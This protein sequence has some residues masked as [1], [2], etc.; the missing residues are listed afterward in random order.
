MNYVKKYKH[1][2]YLVLEDGTYIR[3]FSSNQ[4]CLDMNSFSKKE[5]ELFLQNE[6]ENSKKK[7]VNIENEHVIHP[8]IVIISNGHN[9]SET[10][11][12]LS[13]IDKN[14][15]II[16]V[17]GALKN[18]SLVGNLCPT[19]QKKSI[20]YYVVNNPYEECMRL[21]PSLHRYYPKCI[22]SSRTNSQ[23][24]ESYLGNVFT[25]DPTTDKDY[26]GLSNRH[27]FKIDDYRNPI[28]ASIILA[29]KFKASKL[30]LLNCD[31]S[32]KDE[33]FGA[34]KLENELYSYPAQIKAQKII[35]G[36]L[37]WLKKNGNV[38]I[39]DGSDGIKLNNATYINNTSEVDIL[40][41]FN[42]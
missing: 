4:I 15:T 1:N 19:E 7:Y 25:Y 28:C 40:E 13:K 6:F 17:N 14:V 23:F 36:C 18:W 12:I 3:D 32:F 38:L 34:V 33:R 8:N 10:H 2:Q 9:F 35:D 42:E 37:Y 22:A 24:L 41:F 27:G 16:A 5:H 29:H 11:K 31:D 20:N 30:L 21:L 39:G 26:S